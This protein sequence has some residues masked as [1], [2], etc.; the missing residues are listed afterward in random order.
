MAKLVRI[1]LL[2]MAGTTLSL[3]AQSTSYGQ[4][5][6][7]L[8]SGTASGSISGAG[9]GASATAG[10]SEEELRKRVAQLEAE[11][12]EM[13]E[14]LKRLKQPASS[15]ATA[16]LTPAAAKET[17]HLT[18]NE[19][20]SAG[21]EQAKPDSR[22]QRPGFEVG[23]VR[24][25][26]YGT[27]S[28][29]LFGN[30]GGSNNG[31]VPLF[32][33][34][35]GVGHVS[36]TG[37]ETRFGLRLEGPKI[38]GAKSSG[39]LEADFSGGFPGIGTGEDFGVVR[40]RLAFLKLDWEKT[41]LEAGQDWTIFSPGNPVSLA[42]YGTP[43]FAG[44]GNLYARI[45]QIRLEHR[46][47]DGKISLAGAVLASTTGDYPLSTSSTPVP[48]VLQPGT[49][50]ASRVPAFESRFAFNGKDWFGSAKPG[51][52]GISMHY[53]FARVAPAPHTMDVDVM[54]VAGDWNI[55]FG[56]RVTLA[57]EAFFGRNL[58]GFQGDV[59]QTFI[60]DFAYRVGSRLVP[61]GPRAPGTRGGWA[62]LGYTP[63]TLDDKLSLYAGWGI[64]D[65]RDSDFV[66]LSNRDSRLRNES[67]ELSFIYKF[68]PQLSWGLEYRRMETLY[69]ISNRQNNNH[70]N[71][72]A[73][74]SF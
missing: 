36:A 5:P 41:T 27:I 37:R 10:S 65:P 4:A 18:V 66:S 15:V 64:D 23:P 13:R 62:Q 14:E 39:T 34:P 56:Q 71:L 59:L 54:G 8:A 42:S 16:G 24:V 52:I 30:S 61:G 28:V 43:E 21:T 58:A 69:L 74:Y 57:G 38:A 25:I 35:T 6:A 19:T 55:P 17:A 53:G 32:A 50:A 29:N 51:T 47:L 22:D 33:T 20:T 46:W 73:A 11:M 72:S 26:P 67:Y 31:D 44:A 70:L 45:P 1:L 40:L 2:L 68:L 9:A 63:P 3:L 7:A 60:P 12:Q 48:A 49:G